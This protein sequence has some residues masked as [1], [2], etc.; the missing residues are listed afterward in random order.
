MKDD[1]AA[2]HRKTKR[3]AI[4]DVTFYALDIKSTNVARVFVW[5]MQRTNVVPLVEQ[6]ANDVRANESG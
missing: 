3:V 5:K 6:S 2:F 4:G 1:V